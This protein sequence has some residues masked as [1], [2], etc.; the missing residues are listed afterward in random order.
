MA[1]QQERQV[2]E[3]A[4][5]SK[6]VAHRQPQEKEVHQHSEVAVQYHLEDR[7]NLWR[8][9]AR[10]NHLLPQGRVLRKAK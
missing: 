3:T 6:E 8:A 5:L 2:L 7:C 9:E 10:F 1:A 4:N